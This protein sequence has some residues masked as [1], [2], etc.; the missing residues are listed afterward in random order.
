MTTLRSISPVSIQGLV[1]KK[2]P[3]GEPIFENVNP[4][5]LY[6]DP[7]YQRD[8]GE[9]GLR[10]IR[11]II[12]NFDWAR[13]KPPVCAYSEVDGAT[14]LKCIDGQHTAIGAA[15]NP[16][17]HSIPVMIIEAA[18]TP[19]QALAFIG[20]N[21]ERLG[22]T[23]LQLHRAA[24][25]AGS[26]DA[27]TIEQVCERAGATIRLV[28]SNSGQYAVGETMAVNEIGQLIRR[29]HAMGARQILEL[30]VR[31]QMAPVTQLQIKATEFLLTQ[32]DYKSKFEPGDLIEAITGSFPTDLKQAKLEAADKRIPLWRALASV[33]FRK[34]K[35]RRLTSKGLR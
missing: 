14:V 27:L 31:A 12:E 10:Q 11:R 32:E 34:T 28:Q 30:L 18:D 24:L 21:T 23:K 19:S 13:F 29:R 35:K 26:D 1:P 15:S 9:R 16:F 2:P 25:T 8:V 20:Q 4:A 17:I 5:T 6:V 3:T 22:M 7:D 33:W